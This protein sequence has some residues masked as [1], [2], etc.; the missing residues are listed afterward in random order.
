MPIVARQRGLHIS[1]RKTSESEPYA[2][3]ISV[4]IDTARG[5]V[6]VGGTLINGQPYI[7]RVDDQWVHI[8]PSDGHVIVMHH[9]DKPGMIGAMGTILGRVDINISEMQVGRERE[10]GPAIMLV[11]VDDAVPPD[12][13]QQIRAL[14]GIENAKVVRI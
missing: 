12:V 3:L 1:E 8:R 13:L 4:E 10:R 6:T 9:Q 14:A 11:S 2:N 7:V 5:S